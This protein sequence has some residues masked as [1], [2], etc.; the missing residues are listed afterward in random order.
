MLILLQVI[1]ALSKDKFSI[2]MKII[3]KIWTRVQ[4]PFQARSFEFAPFQKK[5]KGGT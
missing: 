4:T 2:I 1:Y 5:R 3:P